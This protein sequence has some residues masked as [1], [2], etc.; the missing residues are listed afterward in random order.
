MRKLLLLLC[1]SLFPLTSGCAA[2]QQY[3][4]G[5]EGGRGVTTE[6][7]VSGLY[8]ALTV[9]SART[10]DSTS[11]QNGF[12][13]NPLI[14]IQLPSQ[15]TGMMNTLR[16]LGFNQQVDNFVIQM[17]RAAE[18]ASGE[19]LDVLVD[20]VKGITF[21][22]AWG[23]L[24]GDQTA[25]TEYFRART[26]ATLADRFRPIVS[27]KMRELG[28]YQVYDT[29][30][31]AYTALPFT[32]NVAFDL[33]A[34]VVDRSL[35]GL[36]TTLAQEE[37]KIRSNLNFRSTPALKEVFGYLERERAAGREAQPTSA[38][39]SSRGGTSL[40]QGTVK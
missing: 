16:G 39:G 20:T 9:G 38:S 11:K 8:D 1:I 17:N 37:A 24:N 33:E 40:P 5:E 31:N 10:V 4:G 25:A 14:K 35:N 6:L 26:T 13:E 23:I 28:V 29:L 15:L 7:V 12:L 3:V 2:L 34:Y 32:S 18:K 22:D 30:N 19:A 36:F 27:G 21:Q